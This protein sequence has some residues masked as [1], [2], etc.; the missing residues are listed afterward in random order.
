MHVRGSFWLKPQSF[1][2]Q[3]PYFLSEKGC[4]HPWA[5]VLVTIVRRFRH[6]ARA[7]IYFKVQRQTLRSPSWSLVMRGHLS[8]SVALLSD[9]SNCYHVCRERTDKM[10]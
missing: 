6:R 3:S 1:G 2:S 10:K 5:T 7:R 4:P 9:Q 8:L